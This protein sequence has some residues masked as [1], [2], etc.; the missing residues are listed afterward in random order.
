MTTH[1]FSQTEKVFVCLSCFGRTMPAANGWSGMVMD[2]SAASRVH[3]T[4]HRCRYRCGRQVRYML[5]SSPYTGPAF[6][7]AGLAKFEAPVDPEIWESAAPSALAIA[8]PSAVFTP[9]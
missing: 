8:P 2:A 7:K 6:L 4:F 3:A 5:H 9:R 1:A